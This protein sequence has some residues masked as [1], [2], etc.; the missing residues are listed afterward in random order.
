MCCR[1]FYLLVYV[2]HCFATREI[3]I[4]LTLLWANSPP[5]QCIHDTKLVR[6][7]ISS[8]HLFPRWCQAAILYL[9]KVAKVACCSQAMGLLPDTENC[10]LRTRRECRERYPRHRLQRKPQISDHHMHHGKCVSHV[11]WCMSESLTRGGGETFSALPAYAHPQFKVS[12]K[13]PIFHLTVSSML[14]IQSKPR[15]HPK[16]YVKDSTKVAVCCSW[17]TIYLYVSD[18][19]TS[20]PLPQ[21]LEQSKRLP[22]CQ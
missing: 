18:W 14:P 5:L 10:G 21:L 13:R 16:E 15:L 6:Y 8:Q 17:V 7:K 20:L 19:V 1:D 11:P 9:K 2:A 12:C 22:Q 3:N 4:K